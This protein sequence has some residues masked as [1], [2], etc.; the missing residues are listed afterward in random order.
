MREP[1][2][3][4][5]DQ[6]I[7]HG[8]G[9]LAFEAVFTD[10]NGQPE[11]GVPVKFIQVKGDGVLEQSDAVTGH[12]G[13]VCAILTPDG[14]TRRGRVELRYGPKLEHTV[15]FLY[16]VEGTQ[17]DEQTTPPEPVKEEAAALTVA[18]TR[19][20]AVA[21]SDGTTVKQAEAEAAP[22]VERPVVSRPA[23]AMPRQAGERVSGRTGKRTASLTAVR[24]SQVALLAA[25][26]F[27]F[28]L[29]AFS[30]TKRL[31][32]REQP[33]IDLIVDCSKAP[34]AKRVGNVFIRDC[35]LWRQ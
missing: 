31:M 25:I 23:Q 19:V 8:K 2:C 33:K 29:M 18:E 24:P 5:Q 34:P 32:P 17:E 3:K 1:E 22:P 9:D 20:D 35:L 15:P 21:Q 16:V 12:G 4:G 28:G 10:E 7:E 11:T 30:L 26:I 6:V 13:D 14:K 27:T